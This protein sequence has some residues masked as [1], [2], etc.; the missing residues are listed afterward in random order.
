[1]SCW[2]CG[3][4]W[5]LLQQVGLSRVIP[6]R[7]L[8]QRENLLAL[9]IGA[10]QLPHAPGQHPKRVPIHKHWLLQVLQIPICLQDPQIW[11][12][13]VDLPDI[14][15][16]LIDGLSH[17]LWSP[18]FFKATVDL[19]DILHQLMVYPTIYRIS[20]IQGGAGSLPSACSCSPGE[21]PGGTC[22]FCFRSATSLACSSRLAAISLSVW[23]I[24]M[25]GSVK[26]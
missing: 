26:E 15:H 14:L 18:V 16:Q 17:Y 7:R 13:T 1:M 20:T 24:L 11:K 9:K 6:H 19:P 10:I 4:N 22:S 3:R 8:T 21:A 5:V 2:V 12:A 25:D 23:D